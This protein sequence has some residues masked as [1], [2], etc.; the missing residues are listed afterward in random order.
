MYPPLHQSWLAYHVNRRWELRSDSMISLRILN[1]SASIHR[2]VNCEG[3][4]LKCNSIIA[5][6]DY[7]NSPPLVLS[8][9]ESDRQHRQV[10][11]E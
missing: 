3:D 1:Q 10:N 11:G 2:V 9:Q 6:I 8:H 4:S 7:D 5:A